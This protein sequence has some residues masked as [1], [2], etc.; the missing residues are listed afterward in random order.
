MD[1]PAFVLRGTKPQRDRGISLVVLLWSAL[2]FNL[3]FLKA[4][5]GRTVAWI[6][7]QDTVGRTWV[8]ATIKAERVAELLQLTEEYLRLNVVSIKLLRSYVSKAANFATLLFTWRPFLVEI[9]AAVSGSSES[10]RAPNGCIWAKQIAP[11]LRWIRAFLKSQRGSIE[12]VYTLQAH[13]GGGERVLMCT[14]AC[15]WGIGAA[16]FVNGQAVA[17]FAEE[18]KDSDFKFFEAK[19]GDAAGQ[20]VWEALAILVSMRIWAS[21]WKRSRI[22]LEVR[23][24]NVTALTMLASMRVHGRGLT[25][26]ARE[27]ALDIGNGVHRPDVC[28]HSPGVAHKVADALSRKFAPGFSYTVPP[29]LADAAEVAAPSRAPN[30]WRSM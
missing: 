1:D 25:I 23:S 12:R 7:C 30:F 8:L 9:W 18:L 10:S 3:A 13:R 11:A 15:P 27:L 5:R 28:A 26:I 24:D 4:M 22:T 6:G 17:Y 29:C 14:D 20:Q 16:L 2:G 19:R 21:V